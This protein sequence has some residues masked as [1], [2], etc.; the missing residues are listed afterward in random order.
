MQHPYGASLFCAFAVVM[1]FQWHPTVYATPVP[2]RSD[3]PD[4]DDDTPET[5]EKAISKEKANVRVSFKGSANLEARKELVKL[6][7][8]HQPDRPARGTTKATL[9]AR[10]TAGFSQS[11]VGAGRIPSTC[12][13]AH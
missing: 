1:E 2:E 10:V 11:A 13:P 4:T 3:T 12:V 7:M 6:W 8:L 5:S 9:L